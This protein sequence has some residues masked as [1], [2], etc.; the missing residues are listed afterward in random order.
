M[1]D[2]GLAVHVGDRVLQVNAVLL[3]EAVN[4]DPGLIYQPPTHLSLCQFARTIT[5]KRQSFKC[6]TGEVLF[7]CPS[8]VM[9]RAMSSGSG[10]EMVN[11]LWS[12]GVALSN[13]IRTSPRQY[14]P[15]RRR[16]EELQVALRNIARIL[17][18][19]VS[20]ESPLLDAR[21]PDGSR[22]AGFWR[23]AP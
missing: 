18:D 7:S 16:V 15:S 2:G 13:P 19:E 14:Q 9:A 17:G 10:N 1:A 4:F 22:V 5:L 20:P 23:L 8:T 11:T 21:L 12:F 3:E 6:Y